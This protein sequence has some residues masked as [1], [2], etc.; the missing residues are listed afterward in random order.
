MKRILWCA[1]LVLLMMCTVSANSMAQ[2]AIDVTD[3]CKLYS[4]GRK[5][6]SL[7]D[8]KYT[9]YWNSAEKK[10]P[11]LE[12]TIPKDID[13]GYLYIC[14]GEM[15]AKW[16]IE[17]QVDG[18]WITMLEGSPDYLHVL[19][20]LDGRKHV[21]LVDTSGKKTK[22]KINEVF[23]FS[24]GEL[25]E[26]V[27]RWEP[28]TKKADMLLLVAHPDDE[29]IFFGGTIPV[30]D[31]ERGLNVV[32]AYMS[33]SNT[34][35]TSELLN[36]LW[37][38]GVRNYPVIGS[39]YDG[40]SASLE[41]AYKKWRKSEVREYVSGLIRKYKPEVMLTH[42][43]DGEYGHGAHRL[44][45]DVAKYC[46]ENTIREDYLPEQVELYGTWQVKKLYL[47]LYEENQVWMDW[48]QPLS[49]F[50]GK[51][52]LELAQAAYDLHITQEN[53]E[54]V[55][56]DQ[57]ETGCAEFGLYYTTVGQDVLRNDFM[58]NISIDDITGDGPTDPNATPRPT[59]TPSPVPTPTPT[60]EP[61]PEPIKGYAGV[62]WPEDGQK[63]DEKGFLTSG[64]Y[65][66]ADEESGV[67]FYASPTLVIRIDRFFD[68]E[69]VDTWYEAH[70][71]C[72]LAQER[73]GAILYNPNNPT[74]KHVQASVI[75][76]EKKVVFGMNTDYYTY[77]LGRK[78]T[79][80]MVIRGG[81]V[82][83]DRVPGA[84][85]SQFPNLDT[86]AM[87]ENGNWEVFK[88]NELTADEYLADGAVDVFSFGP[89]L[90]KDGEIN[91][92]VDE[93]TKGK[94]DQPRCAIGMIEP[95]HYY[96]VLA[97]GRIKN[98]ATGVSVPWLADHMLSKGCETAFNL[99]GGQTAV[100]TFMGEQITRIGKYDG[101]KT[102]A[103]ATTEIIGIG[104]SDLI[105]QKKK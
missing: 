90:I 81:K 61:T 3:Q 52:G 94:T 58:E 50:G 7:T 5:M 87:Y 86:L 78:A 34:T 97:E 75:A 16:A 99:D 84:N 28:T 12:F 83:F 100:M 13:A 96:A 91:P 49:A 25:P 104:Y 23:I 92:F 80:G 70:V 43:V 72:D 6:G 54:F 76:R 24:E 9:S 20:E 56:T 11:Y 8:R 38:M 22:F 35:R 46:V 18:K 26:W 33:P 15:P 85:R 32:V 63:K 10:A 29:L 74:K 4:D 21:R 69:T 44:C 17:E 79:T 102:S 36:G 103:R 105:E 88:S 62:A 47:H 71:Y 101:G 40:Y 65:V 73:L 37:S 2:E 89:Y 66:F 19:I 77:R 93:S 51:T 82:L 68:A 60:P 59:P 39:F 30:Y 64:E 55:V 98:E 42:D 48:N 67:W 45:A 41:T 57:G 31:V 27:Q 14:F 95:G 53:T 1:C